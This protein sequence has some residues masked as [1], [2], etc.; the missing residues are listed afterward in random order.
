MQGV[1]IYIFVGHFCKVLEAKRKSWYTKI[2]IEICLNRVL[3]SI[4]FSICFDLN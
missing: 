4:N 3:Q 2:V 1:D